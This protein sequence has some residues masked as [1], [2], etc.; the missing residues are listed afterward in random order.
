MTIPSL[1]GVLRVDVKPW[2]PDRAMSLTALEVAHLTFFVGLGAVSAISRFLQCW[3][4]LP[5][6]RHLLPRR[7]QELRSHSTS[8]YFLKKKISD[9]MAIVASED[10]RGFNS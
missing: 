7:E 9:R 10:K 3:R 5:R 1:V 4:H 2:P 8:R 6:M